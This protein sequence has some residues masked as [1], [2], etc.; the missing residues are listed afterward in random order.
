[1]AI[2][3]PGAMKNP[4]GYARA[5][6]AFYGVGFVFFAAAKIQNIRKGHLL[7]FGSSRMSS[8]WKWAYRFGYVLMGI[9]LFLTLVFLVIGNVNG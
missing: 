3:L 6:L 1:M 8:P 4:G 9:G 7:S 2:F 5:A